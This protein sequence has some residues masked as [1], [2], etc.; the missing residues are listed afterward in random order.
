MSTTNNDR[1]QIAASLIISAI[2]SEQINIRADS[3]KETAEL[4]AEAFSVVYEAVKASETQ[5]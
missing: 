3:S 1:S 5:R 4:I 2:Q